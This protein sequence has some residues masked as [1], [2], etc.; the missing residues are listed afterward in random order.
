MLPVLKKFPTHFA[1]PMIDVAEIQRDLNLL[2][3]LT[4]VYQALLGLT[5]TLESTLMAARSD[6][7]RGS[8][9]GYS[10]AQMMAHELPGIETALSPLR[11]IFDRRA[12]SKTPPT[13][14]APKA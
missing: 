7:Y 5:E 1:K 12:K 3:Q 9:K 14:R 10:L 8:L 11:Q 4:P 2:D 6:A 13:P